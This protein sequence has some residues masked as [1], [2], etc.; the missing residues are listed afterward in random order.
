MQQ[1]K[2]KIVCVDRKK[3]S[4]IEGEMHLFFLC[5]G[6]KAIT[7]VIFSG[8]G[9]EASSTLSTLTTESHVQLT[10]ISHSLVSNTFIG[11]L[12]NRMITLLTSNFH[13]NVPRVINCISFNFPNCPYLG[14]KFHG[15]FTT[16]GLW[17]F[18]K[19]V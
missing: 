11:W 13:N 8:V 3:E 6:F 15:H 9:G 1:K 12:I 19:K 14:N 4:E 7:V 2:K 16:E 17:K 5:F 18:Q 10:N